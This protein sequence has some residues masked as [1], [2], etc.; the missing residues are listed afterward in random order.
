MKNKLKGILLSTALLFAVLVQAQERKPLTLNDAIDLSLQNSKQ[1]KSSQAKIEEATAALRES[2][3]KKLPN[4]S[5]A[6]SYLRLNSANIDLKTKSNNSGGG[7]SSAPP[8]VTQ[9][10]YGL[11][12]VSMPIYSGGRIRYGIES[13]ELLQKAAQLDADN[14][15][16]QVIQ[17]TIEAYATLFKAN[18]AVKLVN[19]NLQQSNQRVKELTDLEKNGL[20]ARNDLLKAQLQSSNIELSLLDAQNNL[21]L[22]NLNMDLMLGLPTETILA[23]DTTGIEK[24]DDDRVLDDY[25][26]AAYQNRKD[27]EAMDYRKKAAETG[28]KS[29]KTEMYPSLQ[30]T[31]GYIA[32]DVPKVLT[33]TNAVNIGVGVSYN[34][35]SLWKTKAKVQQAEARAKEMTIAESMMDDNIHLQVSKNYLTLLS[36]RKKIEVYKVA[37]EQ[38]N[39]NYRI[40]K[41]K[42][43][44][45]LATLSDLLEADV[46]KLQANLSYTLARADAFVAYNKLLQ[47]A[48]IL[49]SD[50]KK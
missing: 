4:A 28:I 29:A 46:A 44:N 14:D 12:N 50:L 31:G 42:F 34:I 10:M 36:N 13:S 9:A 23:L 18:T 7:T 21:A 47:S 49:S 48:G 39:E 45:S 41:N 20:L 15:K 5:V 35:A 16:D 2:I 33:V 43:D 17:T 38:A 8:K 6:G 26:K 22:A 1:L 11:L 25:L 37:V 24:K 40:V 3:E 30:L 32:A 27:M 19:E